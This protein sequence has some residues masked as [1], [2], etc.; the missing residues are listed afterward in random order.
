MQAAQVEFAVD[1]REFFEKLA[2]V[3]NAHPERFERLGW[4]DIDLGIVVGRQTGDPLR[5]ALRFRGI[6]C[7]DVRSSFEGDVVD[8][9]IGGDIPAWQAMV[10]DIVAH[11][12]A[13]GR[14]TLSSL[15]L[16]GD[17]IKVS[18]SDPLGVDR[19]FRVA[20]TIQ[21]FFDGAADA[22]GL[23]FAPS[24]DNGSSSMG[25]QPVAAR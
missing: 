15:V 3:M 22:A 7:E 4:C 18:G 13:T 8:C 5:V 23:P 6:C 2:S 25:G 16:L 24:M 9:I 17:R 21:R 1:S 10:D 14:Q 20:E 11:G 19:F 12:Q